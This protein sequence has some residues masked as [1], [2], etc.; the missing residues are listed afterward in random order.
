[1]EFK[2]LGWLRIL[3]RGAH[4]DDVAEILGC[5]RTTVN[6][7]FKLFVNYSEAFYAVHVYVPEGEELDQ[8]VADYYGKQDGFPW[9]RWSMDVTHLMWKKQYPSALRHVCNGRYHCPSVGFIMFRA[10]SMVQQMTLL[11]PTMT[12]IH[13]K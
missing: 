12:L 5:G 11:L 6:D 13:E 10:L 8:V 1:M 7:I 9:L 4:F 2:L 3:G